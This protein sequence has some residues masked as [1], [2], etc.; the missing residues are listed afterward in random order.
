M[1]QILSSIA[2][3]LPSRN[4]ALIALETLAIGTA[5]GLL[6]TGDVPGNVLALDADTGKTLWHAAP[7]SNVTNSPMTYQLDGRQYVVTG[8]GPVLFAWALPNSA[9]VTTAVKR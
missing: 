4:K 1:R 7:G 5:G 3:S 2:L 6:F 9:T 8:A